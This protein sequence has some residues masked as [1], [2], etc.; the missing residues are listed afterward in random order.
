MEKIIHLGTS[1]SPFSAKIQNEIWAFITSLF[2]RSSDSRFSLI[3]L[4]QR[5]KSL[6]FVS[7]KLLLPDYF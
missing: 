5:N 4:T 6:I 1:G 7:G 3:F 2:L